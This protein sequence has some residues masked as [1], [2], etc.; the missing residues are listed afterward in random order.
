MWKKKNGAESVYDIEIQVRNRS[1]MVDE[2]KD[3][4]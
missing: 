3:D 2:A 1:E 4:F